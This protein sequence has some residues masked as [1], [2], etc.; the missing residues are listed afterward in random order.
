MTLAARLT[1]AAALA[2]RRGLSRLVGGMCETDFSGYPDCRR[3]T[4]DALQT[5]LNLG[6]ELDASG[7]LARHGVEMIGAKASAIRTP[8]GSSGPPWSSL[9]M[10]RTAVQ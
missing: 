1:W 3:D 10:P 6:V 8:G 4:L 7:V 2:D 5:A 9:R